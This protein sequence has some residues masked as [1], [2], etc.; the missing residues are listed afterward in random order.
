[1]KHSGESKG[2]P[3]GR[4]LQRPSRSPRH[5]LAGL[6]LAT[7][8]TLAA[9][10]QERVD[11]EVIARLKLE[12]FQNSA[13]MDT[14]SWLTD[15]H[16][17][18]LSG[19]PGLAAAEQWC[20]DQLVRWGL[21][22]VALEPYGTFGRG[23]TLE[24]FSV[25]MTEPRY[26]R[27]IAHP[28]AWSPSL[29]ET[30][31]ATPIRVE[32]A[33]KA[34]IEKYRGMLKG[35]IVMNGKPMPI[36]QGFEPEADRFTDEELRRMESQLD[37]AAAGF[38]APRSYWEEDREW[39]KQSAEE[40]E[41]ASFFRSEG[42][43]VLLEPSAR[44]QGV[45]HVTGFYEQ[46]IPRSTYPAFVVAREHYGRIWRLAERKIP[47]TLE[48]SLRTRFDEANTQGHNVIAEIPGADTAL[49]GEVVMLGA[50]LDSWESG[51]G[52]TDNAAGSAAAM[53]AMRILKAVGVRP[54]RTI[55]LALWTGEEQGYF[56]SVGYVEKH[57]GSVAKGT[58]TAGAETLAAYFNMDNGGGRIRG[59]NLQGNELVR[60]IFDAWLEPFNYLGATALTTLNTGGTDHMPFDAL[61]LPA[62][63]FIQD[64]LAYSTRTHHTHLDTY[65]S[66]IED[67]LKQSA[68][69]LAS[70]AYHAAMRDEKLP[71]KPLAAPPPEAR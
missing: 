25:E 20:R 39:R 64:P 70:F 32:I 28:L 26:M 36:N 42:I 52:A 23:W 2:S 12:G 24:R 53:E 45:L 44:G 46:I 65:E 31:R 17:P 33:G 49:R 3:Q 22:N 60:P 19:S 1:L 6:L 18:R 29:P 51:T 69:I 67:D 55:R 62:F 59:V 58:P 68:V 11:H 14:V 27:V 48:L 40:D 38:G 9:H 37:P 30:I 57:F 66:I 16:G 34:D 63:Q 50:H 5:I 10:A 13:A 61:A 43:A 4:R 71:R 47:V 54:R 21:A 35:A 15:V 56:G 8:A 41:I 7:L